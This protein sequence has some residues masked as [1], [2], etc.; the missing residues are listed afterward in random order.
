VRRRG[1]KKKEKKEKKK[2]KRKET[3]FC[4]SVEEGLDDFHLRILD[5][6]VQRCCA[7]FG[8]RVHVCFGL[9]SVRKE[10]RR[11]EGEEVNMLW[12]GWGW[13]WR[14]ILL[15]HLGLLEESGGGI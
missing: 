10:D 8:E 5:G 7:A 2:K 12:R 4:A 14:S 6:R 3:N 15:K 11:R 13:G 9:E 1:K